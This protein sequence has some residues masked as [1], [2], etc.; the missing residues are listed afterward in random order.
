MIDTED[1]RNR[2]KVSNSEFHNLVMKGFGVKNKNQ[3][4]RVVGEY[5]NFFTVSGASLGPKVWSTGKNSQDLAGFQKVFPIRPTVS[6]YGNGEVALFWLFNYKVKPNQQPLSKAQVG[7]TDPG[8]EADLNIN[9]KNVEVKSYKA[10]KNSLIKLG[11]WTGADGGDIQEMLETLFAIDKLIN[12]KQ[13]A[14]IRTF[15]FKDIIRAADDLCIVRESF[16][17]LNDKD[18]KKFAKFPF[19]EEIASSIKDFDDKLIAKGLTDCFS[20]DHIIPG[21][22]RVGGA[23]IA[24]S[25][26]QY[27]ITKTFKRKPGLKGYFINLAGSGG[28]YDSSR[29]F[30]I[31]AINDAK[32]MSLENVAKP[33]AFTTSDLNLKINTEKL[34][35]NVT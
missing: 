18:K 2:N 6:G 1:T 33:L 28:T 34:F 22:N 32:K 27:L 21:G 25:L 3:V 30:E 23:T 17:S 24:A 35:G 12:K 4:P 11:M 13:S 10:S 15:N 20:P 8:I 29:G 31:T 7:S 14:N 5:N 19:F 26:M 9:G 16:K